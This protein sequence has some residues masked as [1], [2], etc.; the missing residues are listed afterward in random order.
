MTPLA[1]RRV[2]ELFH[3]AVALPAGERTVWAVQACAGDQEL[4]RE[5][6][7][8]LE[9]DRKA[10][11]GF[12][13]DQVKA[14]LVGFY[15]AQKNRARE[16]ERAGPYRLVREIGRGGM[17]TVYLAQ[18]DDQEYHINVAVK[19]VTPGMD[20]GFVLQRFRR[21]R[22]ILASLDHPHIARLLDGGTIGEDLPYI[23][24]EYVDGVRITEYC[25]QRDLSVEQRLRL[26]L[27]VCS[28]V[29]HAHRHFVV[30]RDIKPGNILV[31]QEGVAKL[32]DFGICKLLYSDPLGKDTVT[33]AGRLMT[34]DYASPEQ[35]R[36]EPVTVVSDVYSLAAVL[37]ELLTGTNPHR[38]AN[39]T[40]LEIERTICEQPVLRASRAVQDHGLARRLSGDLDTILF[41]ALDKNPRRR[42]QTV[43]EFAADLQRHLANL[44][45]K[46]V[47]DTLA[48]RAAKF[49]RRRSGAVAAVGV[50]A[51]LMLAGVLIVNREARLANDQLRIDLAVADARIGLLYVAQ[52]DLV[53]AAAAYAEAER[54]AGALASQA[55]SAPALDA[56]RA[57]MK[58][59]EADLA[60]PNPQ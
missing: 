36:G 23:V 46:A 52:R 33:E 41:R 12:V 34:P 37:Y 38:F 29:E 45:V 16:P 44:P 59:L 40:L 21:E 22:Q 6:S 35:I 26:F 57:E 7:S 3:Q 11:E 14:G 4:L 19:L 58:E 30:H 53:R 20:T 28:A 1:W 17:G 24:M 15:E 27:D 2:G 55:G 50:I 5:L 43:E 31:T 25:R 10:R 49:L 42:Y 54:I 48:Y 9:S 51:A 47:P 13:D 8:L 60:S 56:L 32:L 39:R 18:R